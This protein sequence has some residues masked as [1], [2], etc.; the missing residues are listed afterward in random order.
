MLW[1]RCPEL[2]RGW[3]AGWWVP[4]CRTITMRVVARVGEGAARP[5]S[6]YLQPT[7]FLGGVHKRR[8]L[9]RP[10]VGGGALHR[11]KNGQC[12]KP[13]PSAGKETRGWPRKLAGLF[14]FL[15]CNLGM[16]LV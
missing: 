6:L 4:V 5:T 11:V 8:G 9:R 10:S 3:V 7:A 2:I 13:V 14:R 12:L 1:S 15:K 16:S